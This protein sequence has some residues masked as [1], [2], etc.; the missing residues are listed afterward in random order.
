MNFLELCRNVAGRCSVSGVIADT[1]NQTGKFA[2]VVDKVNEAWLEIQQSSDIW[3]F[4]RARFVF[5]TVAN[6]PD[7]SVPLVT[8]AIK[9]GGLSSIRRYMLEDN[10]VAC[11]PKN[12]RAARTFLGEWPFSDYEDAYIYA[13]S[14]PGPP[15]IFAVDEDNTIWLGSIPNGVYTISGKLQ[16]A[17]TS[18]V[19]ATDVPGMP[20]EHHLLIAHLAT[21]KLAADDNL[22]EVYGG[23]E[24]AYKAG[25]KVLDRTQKD[26]LDWGGPLA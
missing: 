12:Q 17:A 7:Y 26:Q 16:L 20:E 23:A 13:D 21:M 22:P 25:F 9:A 18:L 1:V 5:D 4:M 19:A 2:T 24:A 8:E 11:W 14:Q 6:K 15:S 10:S 3:R